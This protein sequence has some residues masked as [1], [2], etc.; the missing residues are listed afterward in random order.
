M[1][2]AECNATDVGKDV[3]GDDKGGGKEEPDHAFEDVVHYKMR[4]DDNKVERHM[5]PG[6]LCE[7]KAVVPLLERGDE[8]DE[9]CNASAE[10][11]P[12]SLP[13]FPILNLFWMKVLTY[14]VQ[15]EAYE[16]VVYRKWKQNLVYQHDVLEIVYDALSVKKVHGGS[17][18]IPVERSRKS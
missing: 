11:F 17:Q 9:A 4:L 2:A 15:H 10:V 8:K 7:L 18:E 13:L 5:S 12:L 1:S 6:E 14:N 3:V 16:A